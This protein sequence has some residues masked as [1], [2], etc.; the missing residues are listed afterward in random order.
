MT[1]HQHQHTHQHRHLRATA[2]ALVTL[3][4]LLGAALVPGA[5]Q[6]EPRPLEDYASYQPQTRCAP[7]AK[8]GTVALGR[9]LVRHHG[10]GFGRI[11]STCSKHTTSEHQEGRAFDWMMSARTKADRREVKEVFERLFRADQAGREDAWARRM[12]IMYLIWDDEIYS[13][14][15]AFEPEPYLSSSCATKKKCSQTLRHRDHVHVSLTRRA[16]RG[17]TSWYDGRLPAKD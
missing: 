17:L 16:G 12:G 4:V 14:W 10:G 2:A 8:P 1:Q 9:W 15:N 6:A 11:G 13:A 5:A 7:G 3:V